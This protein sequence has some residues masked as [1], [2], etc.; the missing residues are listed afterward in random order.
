MIFLGIFALLQLRRVRRDLPGRIQAIREA[1]SKRR[2]RLDDRPSDDAAVR[3]RSPPDRGRRPATSHRHDN[4][5][6]VSI[7]ASRIAVAAQTVGRKCRS[8]ETLCSPRV[9]WSCAGLSLFQTASSSA[10]RKRPPDMTS[11]T[12]AGRDPFA[13]R[14]SSRHLGPRRSCRQVAREYSS[15]PRAPGVTSRST[16]RDDLHHRPVL[17]AEPPLRG[18]NFS[19][20]TAERS[21]SPNPRQGIA[22]ETARGLYRE[23][24]ARS[25]CKPDGFRSSTCSPT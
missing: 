23:E 3:L 6:R 9:Y 22:A 20:P 25:G 5:P 21:S 2:T 18:M 19:E 16:R 13:A 17:R 4:A 14:G 8:L 24:I 10:C 7:I 12:G 15:P 1:R 11:S